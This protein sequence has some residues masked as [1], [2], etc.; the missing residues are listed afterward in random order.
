METHEYIFDDTR[1]RP[2]TLLPQTLESLE[3]YNHAYEQ[4]KLGYF[5][6][7]ST[8]IWCYDGASEKALRNGRNRK[9][10][11]LFA[12]IA[13]HEDSRIEAFVWQNAW[14]QSVM[15]RTTSEEIAEHAESSY[16]TG[17]DSNSW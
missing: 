2:G 4:N 5:E 11:F 17:A 6:E 13:G 3:R 14:A 10:D 9:H 12:K 1:I 8:K 15:P 16:G 7:L